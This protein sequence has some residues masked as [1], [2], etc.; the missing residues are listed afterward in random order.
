MGYEYD[1]FISYRRNEKTKAWIEKHFIPTLNVHIFNELGWNPKF[2]ID[3]QLE[4]G[5]TWPLALGNALGTSKII[6][7]L[8]T[9]TYLNSVWCTA[10]ISRMMKREV[11]T[12]CRTPDRPG[13]LVFPTI[14]HDGESLPINLSIIQKYEIQD[15]YNVNMT[16][17]SAK[18]E[19]LSDRLEPL[20]KAIADTLSNLPEY[21]STWK[22]DTAQ[23]FYDQFFVNVNPE[24]TSAPK[25]IQS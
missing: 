21:Q 1:I 24:Q 5:V 19:L 2:F 7:P 11:D 25:F 15:C 20:G 22:T 6:I 4:A 16:V 10:E 14:I 9:K 17:D 18:A 8:W 13:G 3:S 12:G 23:A